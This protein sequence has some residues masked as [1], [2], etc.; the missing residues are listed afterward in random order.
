[1]RDYCQRFNQSLADLVKVRK[2]AF[3]KKAET[4]HLKINENHFFTELRKEMF[5]LDQAKLADFALPELSSNLM[6]FK[7]LMDLVD[8]FNFNIDL[9]KSIE[10]DPVEELEIEQ[11]KTISNLKDT[12][13]NQRFVL[14]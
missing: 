9:K 5:A 4:K 7:F 3:E 11:I 2:A 6:K 13:R 12:I 14:D 8:S 10:F 1:M